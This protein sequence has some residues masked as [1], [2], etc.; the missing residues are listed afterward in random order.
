MLSLLLLPGL[1]CDRE[2]FAAQEPALAAHHRVHVANVH[3]RAA[4]L[5]EM[6]A[7]L[8]AEHPGAHVLVGA[9]MGG[10]LALEVWRQAPHRVRGIALLGSSARADTPEMQ[11]L[12]QQACKLYAAGRMDELLGA[13][14]MFVFHPDHARDR[15]LVARYL[16]MARR[17]GA[18]QL[19]R[20]NQAVMARVDSRPMLPGIS[21]PVL[22]A[23]GDADG[24][25]TPE[26]AREVAAAIPGARLAIVPHAGHMLTM[27]EPAAVT[28]LLQDWLATVAAAPVV[29][30]A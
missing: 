2:L 10:M 12:R 15:G 16:A 20:Q 14:V 13:N 11:A 22:V 27:E 17:G 30:A 1:A 5:P 24:L 3:T 8:L 25:M 19:I 21:C 23:T 9:S 29:G 4:T 26:M 6:A 28:A 7:L 18:E